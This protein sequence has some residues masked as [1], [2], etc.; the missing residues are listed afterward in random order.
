MAHVFQYK[1]KSCDCSSSDAGT[2]DSFFHY[3]D[4]RTHDV[5]TAADM[6]CPNCG[7]ELEMLIELGDTPRT[8]DAVFDYH[9]QVFRNTRGVAIE[10]HPTWSHA[11]PRCGGPSQIMS[12]NFYSEH[13]ECLEC[14]YQYLVR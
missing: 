14:C 1:C 8:I 13:H 11:C 9:Y 6:S 2:F 3:R 10:T 5:E 4:E 12:V 7:G